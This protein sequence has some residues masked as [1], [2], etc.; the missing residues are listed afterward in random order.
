VLLLPLLL[1]GVP[2]CV[3]Q[4][5]AVGCIF[6]SSKQLEVHHPSVEQLV[7][8]A[9]HSFTQVGGGRS[10]CVVCSGSSCCEDRGCSGGQQQQQQCNALSA[11][12]QQQHEQQ[13]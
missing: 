9:A 5:V 13:H 11:T 8:V 4:L 1:Q 12:R 10:A 3:L 2:R 6:L 7:Q